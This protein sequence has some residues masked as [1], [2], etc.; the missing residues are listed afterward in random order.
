M[1]LYKVKLKNIEWDT[2]DETNHEAINREL[3]HTHTWQ[4]KAESEAS[5]VGKAIDSATDATGYC[6]I[7]S[8]SDT[9]SEEIEPNEGT[10]RNT[11][12]VSEGERRAHPE[13]K[14]ALDAFAKKE[15]LAALQAVEDS[16]RF[17]LRAGN[18]E[19]LGS[20]IESL[21]GLDRYRWTR[22]LIHEAIVNMLIQ[23]SLRSEIILDR[24]D[25]LTVAVYL[26]KT[27]F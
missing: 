11:L 9:T 20:L 21:A 16:I 24:Y 25:T 14:S 15:R 2:S 5:A 6:I 26:K 23:V 17:R 1:R 18:A 10:K 13:A 8:D 22:D 19:S 4:G 27:G 3:G 7:D 12:I